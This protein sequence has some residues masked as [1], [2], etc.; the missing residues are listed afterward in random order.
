MYMEIMKIYGLEIMDGDYEDIR[1]RWAEESLYKVG[2]N[3]LNKF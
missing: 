3:I 1:T 2:L